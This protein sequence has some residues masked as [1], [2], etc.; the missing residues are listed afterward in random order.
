MI[1]MEEYTLISYGQAG[2]D[3]R[4]NRSDTTTPSID[5]TGQSTRTSEAIR[6]EFLKLPDSDQLQPSPMTRL[7]SVLFRL[8]SVGLNVS[9][10]SVKEDV[11]TI[12]RTEHDLHTVDCKAF[13]QRIPDRRAYGSYPDKVAFILDTDQGL[14]TIKKN[15]ELMEYMK[16]V[17][18]V[19]F[20]V[21]QHK[22]FQVKIVGF[23]MLKSP[24]ATYIDGVKTIL[25]QHI[26]DERSEDAI[27]TDYAFIEA[28]ARKVTQLF[29]ESKPKQVIS[30]VAI[31]IRCDE[32]QFKLVSESLLNL[33]QQGNDPHLLGQFI[34][35]DSSD[36][37]VY[38]LNTHNK[39]NHE[40]SVIRVT[41][42]HPDVL[43]EPLVAEGNIEAYP[44]VSILYDATVNN[45]VNGER[46]I[47]SIE[48]SRKSETEGEYFFVTTKE[49]RESALDLIEETMD[50]VRKRST[51][52]K[53][54]LSD[55]HF[56]RGITTPKNSQGKSSPFAQYM[57]V[58]TPAQAN[59]ATAPTYPTYRSQ[60]PTPS[61]Y[62]FDDGISLISEF[63]ENMRKVQGSKPFTKAPIPTQNAWN[64]IGNTRTDHGS[65]GT[66]SAS[67]ATTINS[68]QSA[69]ST[70]TETVTN[71]QDELRNSR[72]INDQRTRQI[73]R[74]E[75]SAER[76]YIEQ[77]KQIA[78][79]QKRNTEQQ[80]EQHMMSSLLLKLYREHIPNADDELAQ[81]FP[82]QNQIAPPRQ[83]PIAQTPIQPAS[84]NTATMPPPTPR[85]ATNQQNMTDNE[86]VNMSV[87]T[88]GIDDFSN[89][90]PSQNTNYV[91]Q[92]Y[93]QY[94]AQHPNFQPF[95]HPM[96]HP[97]EYSPQYQQFGNPQFQ[98]QVHYTNPPMPI[99]PQMG[100]T[101]Y[102]RPQM[103]TFHAQQ[104][105][106]NANAQY[107]HDQPPAT[108]INTDHGTDMSVALT[109]DPS[110]TNEDS[111]YPEGPTGPSG[112]LV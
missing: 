89:T 94:N 69:I 65:I 68:L 51:N 100:Y 107:Q 112:P 5:A 62:V 59:P 16:N 17:A 35:Y 56:R 50:L 37:M 45:L 42:L 30:S 31:Q 52:Y 105:Q 7:R 90:T 110:I 11:G 64:R 28:D 23:L 43:A 86:S 96:G 44:V 102:G 10:R 39:Y 29:G 53:H 15:K 78:E 97:M 82:Q 99:P 41:G 46:I 54:Y 88:L 8:L 3:P 13:F 49:K 55:E 67:N 106:Y 2:S 91:N 47:D 75:E 22:T 6:V 104:A 71:L 84:P 70:L 81:L 98:G 25:E 108:T 18:R 109:E 4:S 72:E 61:I 57:Q 83:T 34:P 63:E 38:W 20:Y 60:K 85:V 76:R 19:F 14:N 73:Q 12:I 36:K 77:Q 27:K 21:N 92:H 74:I 103:Q 95:V 58:I 111:S 32:S 93:T 33:K 24:E 26:N 40:L 101:N 9:F 66:E 80:R 87:P 79:Q 48:P 1:T